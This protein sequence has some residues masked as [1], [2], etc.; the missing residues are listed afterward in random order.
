MGLDETHGG[1][2]DA[3][4]AVGRRDG[5]V[6]PI[7]AR[8]GVG[9]FALAVVATRRAFDDSVDGVA[10]ASGSRQR[11]E[12]QEGGTVGEHSATGVGVEWSAVAVARQHHA[13]TPLIATPVGQFHGDTTGHCQ[14]AFS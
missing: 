14:V 9:L 6:L 2:I 7:L 4:R 11:L 8:C 5:F 10:I 12:Y 13:V 3:R 1:G